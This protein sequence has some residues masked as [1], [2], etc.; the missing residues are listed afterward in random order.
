MINLKI[1]LKLFLNLKKIKYIVMNLIDAL[2]LQN[3][4]FQI[5][6]Q[7]FMNIMKKFKK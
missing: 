1:K 7:E 3:K 5:K 6:Y 4:I 2:L